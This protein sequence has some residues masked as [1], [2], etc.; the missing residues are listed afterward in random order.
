VLTNGKE[1]IIYERTIGNNAVKHIHIFLNKITDQN[2]SK[3][4]RLLQKIIYDLQ[5]ID[6]LSTYFSSVS[7]ISLIDEMS[8]SFF[9][10][11]FKFDE[12]TIFGKLVLGFID[13]FNQTIDASDFIK[14]AYAYWKNSLARKP[15]KIPTTWKPFIAKKNSDMFKV[16]FCIETAQALLSRLIIAKACED[17]EFPGLNIS[18]FTIEK[19]PNYR[20]TIPYLGYP[21]VL[22]N[23]LMEMRDQ[24]IYSIFEEDIFSWWSDAFK[25]YSTKTSIELA[26]IRNDD[27]KEFCTN[28]GKIILT[29][30]K[31]DFKEISGD[32]LGELYQQY[33]DR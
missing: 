11:T 31:F 24:L 3:I 18:K 4:H 22:I 14:G 30:Y 16:M 20:G 2:A 32:P 27:T 23:L 21:I 13:L 8:Q 9:I 1:L 12:K 28:I 19:I 33:F 26:Q 17:T 6:G 29:L 5:N 7:K 15:D 25:K 10:D